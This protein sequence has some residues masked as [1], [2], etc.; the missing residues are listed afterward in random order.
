M[1]AWTCFR[2]PKMTV[3]ESTETE[4]LRTDATAAAWAPLI[5]GGKFLPKQPGQ[6]R[7]MPKPQSA[8]RLFL[9]A[10]AGKHL[11]LFAF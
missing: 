2:A 8:Q 7:C 11:R 9:A 4:I 3:P 10:Q 6:T 5:T 1:L